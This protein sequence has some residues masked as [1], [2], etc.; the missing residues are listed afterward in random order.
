MISETV[1]KNPSVDVGVFASSWD[2]EDQVK[3]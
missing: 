3:L 1:E 2:I